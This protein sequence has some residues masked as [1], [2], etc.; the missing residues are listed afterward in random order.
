MAIA[1]P[2]ELVGFSLTEEQEGRAVELHR[3]SILVDCS[4]VLK[5]EPVHFERAKAGGVTATNHT[6]TRVNSDLAQ[7]L[8]EINSCRRWI[9]ANSDEVLLCLTVDDIYAAKRSGR[10]AVIFGPQNTEFLGTDADFVGTFYDLGVRIM[11]LTYQRQNWVGTRVAAR[12]GWR[13]FDVRQE[14]HRPDGRTGDD[15]RY[16]ALRP[17]NRYGRH[18]A[19]QEPGL[20]T[21]GHLAVLSPHVRAKEDYLLKALAAKGGVIGLTAMSYF[22]YYQDRP[23]EWPNVTRWVE[24]LK[25]LIDLIGID[26]VGVGL[27]FDETNSPR[28]G[29]PTSLRTR[30]QDPLGLGRTSAS[31]P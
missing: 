25:Y 1:S 30:I 13:R 5:Q 20:I 3:A 28:S 4:S 23:F 16:L 9:D 8:R 29:R 11:Q 17:S 26:H 15:R 22:Q 10:E 12:P 31:R 7:A 27:D 19:V 21:H 6:V 14:G 24:H 2:P 18:R